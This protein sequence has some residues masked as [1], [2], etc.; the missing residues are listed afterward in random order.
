MLFSQNATMIILLAKNTIKKIYLLIQAILV[1]NL[2]LYKCKV[3]KIG[4]GRRLEQCTQF[5]QCESYN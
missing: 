2:F 1:F 4:Y 5:S 3:R